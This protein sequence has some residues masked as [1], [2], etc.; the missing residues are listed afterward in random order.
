MRRL[1]F[2]LPEWQ[3][4]VYKTIGGTPHLDRNYTVFGE[5][6]SGLE[7]VDNIAA[8]PTGKGDRPKEDVKMT[9]SILKKKEVKKIEKALKKQL[10]K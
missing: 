2:K 1:K 7:M 3:R 8:Q 4:Q 6:V 5:V 10:V 9:V